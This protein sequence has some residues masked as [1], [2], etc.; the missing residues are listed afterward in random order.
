MKK[1]FFKYAKVY[2][3]L[4]TFVILFL[5]VAPLVLCV[6]YGEIVQQYVGEVG[7]YLSLIL[8]VIFLVSHICFTSLEWLDHRR[9][10]IECYLQRLFDGLLEMWWWFVPPMPLLFG[11]LVVL[12]TVNSWYTERLATIKLYE[13]R[14]ALLKKVNNS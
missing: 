10:G 8:L 14:R 3:A 7:Y 9:C 11:F 2:A 1:H 13:Q 12:G 4:L 6:K 5:S